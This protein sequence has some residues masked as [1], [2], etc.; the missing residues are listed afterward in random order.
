V[1][2]AHAAPSCGRVG[3]AQRGD[4]LHHE[5]P[6]NQAEDVD[7]RGDLERERELASPVDEDSGDDRGHEAGQGAGGVLDTDPPAGGAGPRNDLRD[8]EEGPDGRCC[9]T[10][11]W[12]PRWNRGSSTS[13]QLRLERACGPEAEGATSRCA[14]HELCRSAKEPACCGTKRKRVRIRGIWK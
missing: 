13:S 5:Q 1:F 6:P 3:P 9:V 8:R 4:L 12:K 11:E 14:A 2:Y 10:V 7:R